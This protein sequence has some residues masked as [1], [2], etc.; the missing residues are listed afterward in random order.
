MLLLGEKSQL[1]YVLSNV[2]DIDCGALTEIANGQILYINGTSH[3]DSEVVYDCVQNYRLE[4]SSSSRVCGEDGKWSGVAPQCREIRC[5][6]P[7]RPDG[8]V[9]SIS[10]SD[11]LRAVTLLRNSDRGESSSSSTFRIGSNVIYKCERGFRLDGKNTRTCDESG[12][13]TGEVAVCTCKKIFFFD[14]PT[15]LIDKILS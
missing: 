3:L 7:E 2:T 5:P 6:M 12:Q 14:Y 8:V 10:S 15:G 11:R 13:W 1:F 9:L 4:G